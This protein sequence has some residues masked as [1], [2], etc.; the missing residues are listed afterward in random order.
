M[1]LIM[2]VNKYS[3]K[4]YNKSPLTPIPPPESPLFCIFMVANT[5]RDFF[6]EKSP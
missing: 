2:N 6:E 3:D 4:Y 1:E 5:A